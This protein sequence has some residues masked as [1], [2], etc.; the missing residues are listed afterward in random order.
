MALV[1]AV[2]CVQSL[3]RE[4]SYIAG[5]AKKKKKMVFLMNA[6]HINEAISKWPG[7]PEK[8]VFWF[9]ELVD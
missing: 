7:N 1:T 2:V 3:A 4:L 5:T 8:Y 9:I 6:D